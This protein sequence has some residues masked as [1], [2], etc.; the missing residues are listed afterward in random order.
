MLNRE[1][2]FIIYLRGRPKTILVCEISPYCCNFGEKHMDL[3][4][5]SSMTLLF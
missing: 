5:L 2:I 4:Y 3:L 1:N